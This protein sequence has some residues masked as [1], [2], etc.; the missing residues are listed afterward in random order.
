M[1]DE[2]NFYGDVLYDF[3]VFEVENPVIVTDEETKS[4]VEVEGEPKIEE[5]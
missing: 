2:L 5:A 1:Y 4:V 3:S